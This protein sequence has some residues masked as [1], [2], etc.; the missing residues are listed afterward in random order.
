[1]FIP[2]IEK[3]SKKHYDFICNIF[4][5][6]LDLCDF[7]NRDDLFIIVV[8]DKGKLIGLT[9][10]RLINIKN[11]NIYLVVFTIVNE[12]Y[13]GK[14]NNQILLNYLYHYGKKINYRIPDFILEY[15]YFNNQLYLYELYK[16]YDH[17]ISVYK[18][19]IKKMNTV[20]KQLLKYIIGIYKMLFH[21]ENINKKTHKVNYTNNKQKN[22]SNKD[23]KRDKIIANIRENNLSSINSF[24]K[25]GYKKSKK[26]TK[27]YKNGEKKIRVYKYI[28]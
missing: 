20:Y 26:Y 12:N 17:I 5:P 28:E 2:K 19:I 11:N 4:D 22:Y 10:V 21:E 13:R 25:N 15:L 27:P 7:I 1:M 9:L 23:N 18:I 8:R 24:I 3:K 14:G 16:L 6:Y